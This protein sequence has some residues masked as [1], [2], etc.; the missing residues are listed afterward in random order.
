MNRKRKVKAI[1]VDIDGTL[2]IKGDRDIFDFKKCELDTVNEPIAE[3]VRSLKY[4]WEIILLSGREDICRE[5][6]LRW[7]DKNNIPYSELHM[8]RASD[9]RK[10]AIVKK[11]IY[12]NNIKDNY[13]IVFVLDDRNQ[14]VDFWRSEGLTCLQVAAGDF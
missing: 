3:L 10:D 8:R 6:T 4:K 1:I 5:E 2:A 13:E 12:D 9:H 11:E 14:V 7:L